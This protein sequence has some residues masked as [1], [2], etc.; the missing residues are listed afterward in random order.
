MQ[1]DFDRLPD[2][3]L[4]ITEARRRYLAGEL[5]PEVYTVIREARA[6]LKATGKARSQKVLNKHLFR[7][8]VEHG[9]MITPR[10]GTLL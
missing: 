10:Q 8:L 7:Q 2:P 1:A 4:T 9:A 5:S 6:Y 3:T